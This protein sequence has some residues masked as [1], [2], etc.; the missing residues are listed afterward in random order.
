MEQSGNYAAKWDAQINLSREECVEGMGQRRNNAEAK[1]AQIF[2]KREECASGTGQQR[3]VKQF[4]AVKDA[5]FMVNKDEHVIDMVQ[6]QTVQYRRMHKFLPERG[7]VGMHGTKRKQLCNTEGC[8][9]FV[10]QWSMSEGWGK[11]GRASQF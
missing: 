8:T 2:L 4:V 1:G 9:N 3:D 6:Q 5:N 7:S 10:Q 11:N